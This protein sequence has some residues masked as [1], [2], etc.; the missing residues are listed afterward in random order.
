MGAESLIKLAADED[1]NNRILRGLIRREHDIDLIRIQDT[2]MA[3]AQDHAVLEWT[4]KEN[5]VLLTHDA[6][7]MP[8]QAYERMAAGRPVCGI[9]VVPQVLPIR[10]AI[11][12]ILILVTC[13]SQ[14]EWENRIQYLPLR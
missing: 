10:I 14:Q 5:R 2:S 13:T 3:E 6:K 9:I 7:T 1:F 8:R 4:V 11:E 12:D